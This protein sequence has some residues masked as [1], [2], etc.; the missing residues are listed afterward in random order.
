MKN[1]QL[2]V[3]STGF[4]ASGIP[5]LSFLKYLIDLYSDE[6]SEGEYNYN[7]LRKIF[8][9]SVRMVSRYSVRVT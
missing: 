6:Q 4:L 2:F 1:Q 3:F 8:W 7:Y 5:I 9:C